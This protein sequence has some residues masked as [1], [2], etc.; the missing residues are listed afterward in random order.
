MFKTENMH[1]KSVLPIVMMIL[2]GM[3]TG[4][5]ESGIC[6]SNTVKGLL[7]SSRYTRLALRIAGDL[8]AKTK[9]I[10]LSGGA[11]CGGKKSR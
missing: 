4:K 1:S 8:A 6:G 2:K 7:K 3:C 10:D 5:V 11:A 9:G